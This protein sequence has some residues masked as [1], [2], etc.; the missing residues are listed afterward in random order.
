[1]QDRL[2]VDS[3]LQN[4]MIYGN[5]R[6]IIPHKSLGIRKYIH[7]PFVILWLIIWIFIEIIAIAALPNLKAGIVFFIL[8]WVVVWTLACITMI[9]HFYKMLQKQIPEKITLNKP[10]LNFDSGRAPHP[11]PFDRISK[12]YDK[13]F[14]SLLI[15]R[16]HYQFTPKEIETLALRDT[17]D[18]N[19]LTIDHDGNR[20]DLATGATE[21]QK[22]WLYNFL[23]ENYS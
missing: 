18:N 4:D 14:K 1:M 12:N 2:T 10:Y 5:L 13:I 8:A 11:S 16:K 7:F 19:R 15:K 21:I 20:I 22:E 6:F 17:A 9:A 23:K 3:P